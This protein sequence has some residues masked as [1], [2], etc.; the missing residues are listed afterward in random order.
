MNRPK[1][2]AT[3]WATVL[4]GRRHGR[5]SLGSATVSVTP[6]FPIGWPH[7]KTYLP[8]R[9]NVATRLKLSSPTTVRWQ[10]MPRP[11]LGSP[12][13]LPSKP[14]TSFRSEAPPT[15]EVRADCNTPLKPHHYTQGTPYPSSNRGFCVRA[16]VTVQT[17][18]IRTRIS[19]G[20]RNV[21]QSASESRR[22]SVCNRVLSTT[23]AAARNCP[24]LRIIHIG[25]LSAVAQCPPP[26][27]ARIQS[28]TNPGT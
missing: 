25:D 15:D 17:R 28:T 18:T 6:T 22:H 20:V 21:G 4:N 10:P 11:R 8:W 13:C 9:L 26:A 23:A 16:M 27:R 19:S 14:R 12:F 7:S 1:M 3:L 24:C 2:S 5:K